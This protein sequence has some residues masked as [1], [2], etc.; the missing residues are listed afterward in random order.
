MTE[1]SRFWDGSTVGDA[2]SITDDEFM[3]RFF[4]AILN[5]TGD[6]GVLRNWLNELAVTDGG[7]LNAAVNTGAAINYGLF[8]ENTAAVN[9]AC[10]NNSTVHVVVRRDWATPESRLTQVA[11]LVQNPGVTYDIPLAEVTTVAGAI[12]LITDE[13]DFC[14]FTTQMAE[15]VVETEHIQDDAVT[16]A[17]LENHTRWVCRAAGCLEPD[18]TNPAAFEYNGSYPQSWLW[19]F[20]PDVTESVWCTFRVP[21]DIVGTDVDIYL[22]TAEGVGAADVVWAYSSY[23]A[24]PSAVLANQSG[25]VTLTYNSDSPNYARRDLLDTMTLAAGDIVHVRIDR[26]GADG[27]DTLIYDAQLYMVEFAYTADS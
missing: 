4:R 18:G 25:N 6:Q 5:G 20:D 14:E 7:G 12:T 10:P 15:D 8:Y 11:A 26:L 27:G 16:P 24:Q 22:W 21:E 19:K 2:V 13:R 9:V 23:D 1:R 17:K 3:D